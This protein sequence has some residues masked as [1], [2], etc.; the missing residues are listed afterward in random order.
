MYDFLIYLKTLMK[1][2]SVLTIF[3]LFVAW[4]FD[5]Q[6]FR[7]LVGLGIIYIIIE[8]SLRNTNEYD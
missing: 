4:D 5:W 2:I 7:Y 1:I 8:Y 6:A 3:I